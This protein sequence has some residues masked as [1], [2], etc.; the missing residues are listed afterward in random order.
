MTRPIQQSWAEAARRFVAEYPRHRHDVRFAGGGVRMSP[1]RLG[2]LRRGR[3]GTYPCT[4]R[5]GNRIG[6]RND[7]R[8]SHPVWKG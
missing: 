4:G 5:G 2:V 7:G 6:D 3:R 1:H 8:A